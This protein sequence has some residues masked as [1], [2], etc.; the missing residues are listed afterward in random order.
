MS[1]RPVSPYHFAFFRMALGLYLLVH[2]VMLIPCAEELWGPEGMIAEPSLNLTGGVLPLA[3]VNSP[4]V[5]TGLVILLSLLGTALL[6][7]WQRPMVSV[8]LW[9]GWASLFDRNNLISNPGIPYVGWLLLVCAVVPKGEP[10]SIGTAREGWHLPRA[11]YLGAWL[12]MAVG[13][14]ISG[15]DKWL[16]PSWRDGTAIVHL[17]ENPLARDTWLREWM[18]SWPQGL[19]RTMTWSILAMEVL[20]LPLALFARTR[21][22]AWGGMVLMHLDILCIVDFADLTIGMLMIHAFTLDERWLK[23]TK[24]RSGVLFFDGVCGLCNSFVDLLFAEDRHGV[25]RVTALQGSTAQELLPAVLR[26][27]NLTTVVYQR[28][29]KTW[30][31]S[32]A[33]LRVL[34]DLGGI[35]KLGSVLLVVPAPLRNVV[36]DFVARNRIK[37]FGQK[38]TCRMPTPEERSRFL[39]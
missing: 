9:L 13:Y 8:L 28:N 1:L 23:P 38:E 16:A 11:L 18:L 2:F 22:F 7:G 31:R 4:G 10:L 33:A 14:T 20:F 26:Q 30:T 39:P 5:A 36:Y 24:D 17:L 32:G 19:H 6:L 12:L 3:W 21:F 25:L 29:G 35:W 34:H 37:W 27:G 15:I